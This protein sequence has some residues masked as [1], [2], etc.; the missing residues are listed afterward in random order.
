MFRVNDLK[1]GYMFFSFSNEKSLS[2]R[3]TL[4]DDFFSK[5]RDY[6]NQ[7]ELKG[8]VENGY[9]A[10]DEKQCYVVR[11]QQIPPELES[12]VPYVLQV[13]HVALSI[14]AEI[15]HDLGLSP[16]KLTNMVSKTPLPEFDKATSVLRLFAYSASADEGIATD[17][18]VDIGLITIIPLAHVPALEILDFSDLFPNWV[19][20]EFS[21]KPAQAIVLVGKTLSVISEGRYPSATHRVKKSEQRRISIVYQV[22]AEPDCLINYED[23]MITIEEWTRTIRQGKRSVNQSF[24]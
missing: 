9:S 24:S 10:L 3:F 23:E 17:S 6:L 7:F 22:R 19:N 11:S 12:F 5:P 2:E 13:H 21:Q 1:N 16:G 4:V 20:V 15:E 14:L 18:H 8:E